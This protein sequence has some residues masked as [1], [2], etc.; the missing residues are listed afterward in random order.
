M[1]GDDPRL[2]ELIAE[3]AAE[4]Y[5]AHR[6]GP[7]TAAQRTEFMHWLRSS[8][9]HVAEYLAVAGAAEAM[10]DAARRH[11]ASVAALAAAARIEADVVSLPGIGAAR[12]PA[13]A[14]RRRRLSPALAAV[15]SLLLV[16]VT[17]WA[18][19]PLI[20]QH[21]VTRHGEQRSWQLPDSSVVRLNSDSAIRVRFRDG[22]RRIDIRRGQ[23]YFEVAHDPQRPFHVRAGEHT[24]ESVG[25]VFDVYRRDAA[26]T[27]TVV[28]G[29][30]RVW[31]QRLPDAVPAVVEAA[32]G[33]PLADIV[34]GGQVEVAKAAATGGMPLRIT[35][36][37][38]LQVQKATAWVQEKIIFRGDAIA[39]VAAEFNR[40]NR[41]QIEILDAEVGAIAISGNFRSHDVRSFVD[42]LNGL[43][44]VRAE[45]HERRILV[46]RADGR[47]GGVPDSALR[48][49]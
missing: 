13:P 30:V 44:G 1:R 24:I 8:P 33:A 20:G 4:W 32:V 49:S 35:A 14:R 19:T 39:D 43:P 31:D 37:D 3:T 42:F 17:L 11:P 41:Q 47:R 9:Q 18:V 48:P 25:T 45:L 6:E 16:A 36:E 40:Y 23:V 28:E 15:A 34:A 2:R 7:L 5:V 12:R 46:S 38:P 22:H 27:V 21:Y 26:T 10:G 29:R